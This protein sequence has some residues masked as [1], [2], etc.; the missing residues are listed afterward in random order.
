MRA[1]ATA[2]LDLIPYAATNHAAAAP[3]R[4]VMNSRRFMLSLRPGAHPTTSFE[5]SVVHHSTIA[6]LMTGSG[7]NAKN[8]H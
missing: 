2:A 8:S 4:S 5:S 1:S 7:Q 3:L 6:P